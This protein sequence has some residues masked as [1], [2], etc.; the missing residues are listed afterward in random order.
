MHAGINETEADRIRRIYAEYER[1]PR[2]QT[3]RNPSNRGNVLIEGERASVTDELLATLGA[4]QLSDAEVLDVGCGAGDELARL[5]TIGA[6]PT[7]C[8]GVDLIPDRV[9]RAR[10][11]LPASDI[12]QGDAR[13]LPYATVSMDLVVL[14]VVLSSVIDRD[15][16][17]E[18]A[19]EID[20]VLRPGGAVLWYDN[21]YANPFN[22]EVRGI[23][24]RELAAL[25]PRY[26]LRLRT[27]T[28]LPPLARRL[29]TAADRVYHVL[30]RTKLLNV[31]YAG[32]L[33]KSKPV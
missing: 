9:A 8:H 7:R 20:R 16:T 5:Q 19:A 23:S 26:E 1:D 18:I 17:A 4:I 22:P 6:D 2:V 32:L 3:R 27:I 15:V 24:R 11:R 33:V 12:R 30:S 29:G 14:K 21:R 28:V 31:R 25:F 13:E 10:E